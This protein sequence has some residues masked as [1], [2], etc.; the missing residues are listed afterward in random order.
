[1]AAAVLSNSRAFSTTASAPDAA[2]TAF[3]FGQP[4]RGRTS[5]NSPSPQFIMRAP[6]VPMFSPSCGS[7]R[8]TDRGGGGRRVVLVSISS[9]MSQSGLRDRRGH[10]ASHQLAH[11][12]PPKFAPARKSFR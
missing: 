6:P 3:G 12:R 11:R 1:M 9:A 10:D 7:T 8:M 5:R 4:S 2:A